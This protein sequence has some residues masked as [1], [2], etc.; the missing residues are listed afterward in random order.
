MGREPVYVEVSGRE[1]GHI[2]LRSTTEVMGTGTV[3]IHWDTIHIETHRLVTFRLDTFPLVTEVSVCP[4]SRTLEV[5]D[6]EVSSPLDPLEFHEVIFVTLFP[7]GGVETRLTIVIRSIRG[8]PF[9][10]L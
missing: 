4:T 2:P 7:S 1:R 10:E 3:G 9:K 8:N 6:L 5:V